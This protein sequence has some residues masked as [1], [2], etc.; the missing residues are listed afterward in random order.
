VEQNWYF[1]STVTISN[2]VIAVQAATLEN[3]N[4]GSMVT[5]SSI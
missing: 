5:E 2:E 1:C 3:G 4:Y